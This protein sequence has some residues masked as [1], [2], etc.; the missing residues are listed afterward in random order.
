MP[1]YMDC[2]TRLRQHSFSPGPRSHTGACAPSWFTHICR[3]MHFSPAHSHLPAHTLR[4]G[5][6][7]SAGACIFSRFIRSFRCLLFTF[8]FYAESTGD[9]LA[10]SERDLQKQ[11]QSRKLCK[12]EKPGLQIATGSLT[13]YLIPG[14]YRQSSQLP[15]P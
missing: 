10:P 3:Y 9:I 12:S 13:G 2:L 7:S 8:P 6:L 4:L 5:S 14:Q 11:L 1:A 15:L